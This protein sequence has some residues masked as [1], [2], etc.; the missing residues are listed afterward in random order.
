MQYEWD[1]TKAESNLQKHGV[2]FVS[3]LAFEWEYAIVREDDRS[4]YGEPRWIAYAPIKG[5]LHIM[6][7]TLRNNV[8]RLISLRKANAREVTLYETAT[9]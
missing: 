3:A 6:I 8:I 5:R 9:D 2:S 1:D 4:N 7:Y